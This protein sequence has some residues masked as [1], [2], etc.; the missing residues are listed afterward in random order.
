[1]RSPFNHH[2]QI[3][4]SSRQPPRDDGLL[5]HSSILTPF[6]SDAIYGV[7]QICTSLRPFIFTFSRLRND[8]RRGEIIAL[9]Q[10]F[11]LLFLEHV[12]HAEPIVL[13]SPS[14]DSTLR[15]LK[16]WYYAIY[17]HNP[18]LGL[19]YSTLVHYPENDIGLIC[20][21]R[22]TTGMKTKHIKCISSRFFTIS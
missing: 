10:V 6:W 15:K 20:P 2:A 21:S 12:D 4:V 19:T 14:L 13:I 18:L 1:M 7:F 3:I 11:P 17:L 22:L 5:I 16:S 8:R 9:P